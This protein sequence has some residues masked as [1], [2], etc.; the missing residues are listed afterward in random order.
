MFENIDLVL[1]IDNLRQFGLTEEEIEGYLI[2][3]ENTYQE[4]CSNEYV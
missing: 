3:F 2:F 1:D 4:L